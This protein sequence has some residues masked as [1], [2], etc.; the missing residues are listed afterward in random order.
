ML[1]ATSSAS[2]LM[3][4]R[5]TSSLARRSHLYSSFATTTTATVE[6]TSSNAAYDSISTMSTFLW[7]NQPAFWWSTMT[8]F[9]LT[10]VAESVWNMSSTLKKRRAKMNKHKLNKRRKKMRLK[11][12]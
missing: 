4:Q 5:A 8:S 12:K 11:S 10:E 2:R 9:L 7:A 1:S 6:T 3:F